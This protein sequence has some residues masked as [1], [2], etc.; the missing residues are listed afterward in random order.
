MFTRGGYLEN[1]IALDTVIEK[2]IA[3][4]IKAKDILMEED[5]MH[6]S[7]GGIN[8]MQHH[9]NE[10]T[11]SLNE[12]LGGRTQ[13]NTH[14]THEKLKHFFNLIKASFLKSA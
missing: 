3:E 5:W 11:D 9:V 2:N 1:K 12:Y 7:Y 8:H 13:K 10:V 4:F 6:N 14:E